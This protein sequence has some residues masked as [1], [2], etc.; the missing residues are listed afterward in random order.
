MSIDIQ[1]FYFLISKGMRRLRDF[2][3]TAEFIDVIIQD[4]YIVQKSY[5][6]DT[7]IE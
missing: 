4:Q 2:G 1:L 6:R 5:R 3:E 7:N